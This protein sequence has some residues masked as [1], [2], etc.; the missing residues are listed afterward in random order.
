MNII[1]SNTYKGMTIQRIKYVNRFKKLIYISYHVCVCLT[2]GEHWL[3]QEIGMSGGY[4]SNL[5]K[6]ILWGTDMFFYNMVPGAV[7]KLGYANGGV[8]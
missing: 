7:V 5:L 2:K 8:G 4:I 1:K 6:F 3:L